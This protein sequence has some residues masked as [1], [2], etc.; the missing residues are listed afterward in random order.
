LN[1]LG[2]FALNSSGDWNLSIMAS[3]TLSTFSQVFQETQIISSFEIPITFSIS[4]ETL[5][6]FAAGKS[7]LLRTGIISSP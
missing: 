2:F 3:N 4:L 7:I 1:F 6:G 5:S